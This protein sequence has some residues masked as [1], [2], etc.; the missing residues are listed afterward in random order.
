MIGLWRAWIDANR[1][2][3]EIQQ[4]IALRLMRL[5]SGDV[6]AAGEAHRMM[7]EKIA[8]GVA[9]QTAAAAA[10][11][12]GASLAAVTC[13]AARPFRTRVRANHRRLTG[14]H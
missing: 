14:R 8:A 1:F 9:A 11:I 13:S 3:M 2:A 12:A 7:A 4:V 6:A 10:L 5:A